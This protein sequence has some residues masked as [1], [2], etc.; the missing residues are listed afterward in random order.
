[1][2]KVDTETWRLQGAE[3]VDVVRVTAAR[4]SPRVPLRPAL[5]NGKEAETICPE[6]AVKLTGPPMAA[7]LALRNEIDPV[8]EAAV[9]DDEAGAT[10][11]TLT[12]AVSVLPRPKTGSIVAR[13][14]VPLVWAIE[15]VAN[16]TTPTA[17][18]LAIIFT[19]VCLFLKPGS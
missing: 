18:I 17:I 7:P 14:T 16:K 5:E 3:A 15:D 2:S 10:F 4:I 1:V 9:P 8:H 6:P 11:T 19:S 12:R 13:V